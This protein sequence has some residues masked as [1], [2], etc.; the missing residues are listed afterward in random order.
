MRTLIQV[1]KETANK[2]KELRLAEME[3]YDEIINRLL[4]DAKDKH[5]GTQAK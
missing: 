3:T 2:L 5:S 4:K 1:E